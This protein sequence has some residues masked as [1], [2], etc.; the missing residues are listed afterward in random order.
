MKLDETSQFITLDWDN[1]SIGEAE[2]RV[3][4]LFENHPNIERIRLHESA[5]KGFHCRIKFR[6]PVRIVAARLNLGDDCRRLVH[7]IIRPHAQHD[8]LWNYKVIKGTKFA[9]KE[10][11]DYAR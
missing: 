9:T 11:L 7:D 5:T 8:I 1:I 4:S 6:Y 10:L 3:K 2:A